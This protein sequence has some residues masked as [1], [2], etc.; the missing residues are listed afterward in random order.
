M[1]QLRFVVNMILA[2]SVGM[3]AQT[4]EPVLLSANIPFYP[5]LARQARVYGSVKIAFTL[6]ANSGEPADVEAVSGHPLLKAA[7]MENV[8]TWRFRNTY[9][10][11]RKY[12]T[13][14]HYVLT[15]SESPHVTFESFTVVEIVSLKPPPLDSHF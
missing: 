4:N 9:S 12:E 6:P 14:F 10:V 15:E 11:E 13:A 8:K 5:P 1:R 2:I 3:T 7:A